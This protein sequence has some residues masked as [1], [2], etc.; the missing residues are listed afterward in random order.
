MPSMKPK[1]RSWWIFL[2]LVASPVLA[3]WGYEYMNLSPSPSVLFAP[4]EP[5]VSQALW[6]PAVA[7][8][9]PARAMSVASWLGGVTLGA[10]HWNLK[11]GTQIHL[12][13]M[14]SGTLDKTD[15]TGQV[16]GTFST[17]HLYIG[18]TFQR[19]LSPTWTLGFGMGLYAQSIPPYSSLAV[20]GAVGVLWHPA[21]RPLRMAVSLANVGVELKPMVKDRYNPA[22]QFRATA[23]YAVGEAVQL[24]LGAVLSP[25]GSWV[26]LAGRYHLTSLLSL[27]LAYTSQWSALKLG[28]PNDFLMGVM[29]GL[30]LHWRRIRFTYAY[31]P[32]ASLGDLHLVSLS[33]Y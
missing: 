7:S 16:V 5:G 25:L 15:G 2:W 1:L 12:Q 14:F 22:P 26:Q 21:P 4:L 20:G 31:G 23:Q 24:S 3:G 32:M 30:E 17:Q 13:G 19:P 28:D 8:P 33:V 11:P 9:H 18:S 27:S 29:P 10:F 6:H